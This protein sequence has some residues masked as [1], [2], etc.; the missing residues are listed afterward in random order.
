MYKAN[1]RVITKGND[2]QQFNTGR[3]LHYDKELLNCNDD[4]PVVMFDGATEPMMCFGMTVPYSD[5]MSGRLQALTPAQQYMLLW[6]IHD[7]NNGKEL[8]LMRGLPGSGKSTKAKS[9]AGDFGQVFSTDDY[10]CLNEENEYR[11]DA[12]L[13]H[14][15]H[16]WNQRRSLAAMTANIPIVVIDNTNTTVRE[17]R[18]HL[19]HIELARQLGYT[20]RIEESDTEWR[21]RANELFARGSHNVPQAHI[22]KM[23]N[24]YAKDVQVEDIIFKD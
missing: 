9:L 8:I 3:F 23:L 14:K 12:T 22:E 15:A 6:T 20:V 1:D 11:F 24:R 10:F 21:F 13:L 17:L 2:D 7:W 5:E 4:I 18:S 16:K 19:P